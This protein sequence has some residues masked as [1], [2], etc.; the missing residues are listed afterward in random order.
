M[1]DAAAT[2][3]TAPARMRAR[4]ASGRI[5]LVP[6]AF[7]AL[8]A[9]VIQRAGA[10]AIYFT[11]AGFA[12]AQFAVPDV[13]LVTMTETVEQVRR[14]VSA[15]DVPLI[16]D[17][18]TG[19]GGIL[20]VVRTTRELEAAGVAAIQIE[21]QAIPKRCGHFS[22]KVVV[23]VE[24]MVGRISAA[25]DTRR[26]RS[27]LIIARTDSRQS[28]GIEA[29]IERANLYA[30]AGA[31]LAFIEAP[32]TVAEMQRIPREVALPT[33]ANLVE[34]GTTPIL[35]AAELDRMGFRVAIYA[36]T[37][38]RVAAKA[39]ENAIR[40]LLA[41]GGSASLEVQM[42]SWDERQ[43]LVRLAEFQQLE[44]RFAPPS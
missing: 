36:N 7:D 3:L 29:A 37:A 44:E 14:I 6:G 27:L 25:C 24:E 13:G 42:L 31:D 33:V 21:D 41:N 20:N 11:G 15:I 5:L 39:V 28:E 12:N 8:S 18:D 32:H 35:P 40:D 26:N 19:Y 34:G 16:A 10:E 4:V 43:T 22:G 2:G 17:A 9:R 30:R 23:S 1:D 38:L